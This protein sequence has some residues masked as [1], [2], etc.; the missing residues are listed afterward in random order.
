M[1]LCQRPRLSPL[2]V[3][4]LLESCS[5]FLLPFPYV[6]ISCIVSIYDSAL[7][8]I[9]R[10]PPPMSTD[11]ATWKTAWRVLQKRKLGLPSVPSAPPLG[12]YPKSLIRKDTCT[13]LFKAT[14]FSIAKIW[15]QLQCPST[16]EGSKQAQGIYATQSLKT[17]KQTKKKN[18]NFAILQ[19][20]G[21][22]WRASRK[23]KEVR[24]RQVISYLIS[25]TCGT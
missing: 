5:G 21:W 11:A 17:N 18:R 4:F 14:T 1:W 22:T 12:V 6:D 25:L 3:A 9:R 23:V 2:N 20:Q 19:Q 10:T 15:K 7:V 8:T 24:E 13:P 16:Q